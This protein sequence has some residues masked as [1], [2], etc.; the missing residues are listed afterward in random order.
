MDER[1]DA[2]LRLQEI[3]SDIEHAQ[4]ELDA[5]PIRTRVAENELTR[6]VEALQAIK[7]E[8]TDLQKEADRRELEVRSGEDRIA[9]LEQQ[10]VN[11]RTNREYA[12]ISTQIGGAEADKARLEDQA[13]AA[14]AKIDEAR[15]AVAAQ[16]AEV[17]RITAKR[18]DVLAVNREEAKRIEARLKDLH[19]GH[20]EAQEAVP[21]EAL[22][23]YRRLRRRL[24]GPPLAGVRDEA[25][26]GCHMSVSPQTYSLLRLGRDLIQCTSCSRILYLDGDAS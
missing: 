22:E 24:G 1:L 2:L 12:A 4:E 10:R 14:Y 19:E 18:D 9:K 20:V 11:V 17:A 13:L 8:L 7:D 3:D 15:K 26:M 23:L 16:E 21:S 6:A 25:C 5:L